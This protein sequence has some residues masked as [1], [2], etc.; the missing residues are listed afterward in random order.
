MDDQFSF[1]LPPLVDLAL[2][3]VQALL[4]LSRTKLVVVEPPNMYHN[5]SRWDEP[6]AY[7]T[8]TG[9]SRYKPRQ[10]LSQPNGYQAQ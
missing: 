6:P 8:Q 4:K 2:P 5:F 1:R 7:H 3:A 9:A 10:F